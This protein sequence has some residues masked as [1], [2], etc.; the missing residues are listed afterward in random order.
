MALTS[1]IVGLAFTAYLFA[2]RTVEGWDRSVTLVN[3]AHL[4]M[5]RAA[6]DLRGAEV[7]PVPVDAVDGSWA[8]SLTDSEGAYEEVAYV[9]EGGRLLRN[10]HPMHGGDVVVDTFAISA[11]ATAPL[12]GMPARFAEDRSGRGE[13]AREAYRVRL[14]LRSGLRTLTVHTAVTPR[15]RGS[16]AALPPAPAAS[17]APPPSDTDDARRR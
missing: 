6:E 12:P 3:T 11:Q 17:G 4:V 7:P 16:W 15:S 8:V 10:G 13:R 9:L 1:L 14:V 2:R 5:H